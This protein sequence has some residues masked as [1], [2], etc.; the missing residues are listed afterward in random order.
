MLRS[1]GLDAFG[2]SFKQLVE[3]YRRSNDFEAMRFKNDTETV[4]L[5]P[6]LPENDVRTVR[7]SFQCVGP[8]ATWTHA[9]GSS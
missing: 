9:C 5:P 8:V 3:S 6:P 7:T 4:P 2:F 1:E